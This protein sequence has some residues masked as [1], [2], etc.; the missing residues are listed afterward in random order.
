MNPKTVQACKDAAVLY[1]PTMVKK[2]VDQ[3]PDA[4]ASTRDKIK[5][6]LHQDVADDGLEGLRQCS[7]DLR[8]K[9]TE[10]SERVYRP[11]L[12]LESHAVYCTF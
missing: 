3:L 7:A 1:L 8:E 9:A 10:N 2:A 5:A 12:D 4:P 11:S 6:A